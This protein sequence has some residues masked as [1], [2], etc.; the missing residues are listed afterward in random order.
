MLEN[1]ILK[2]MEILTNLKKNHGADFGLFLR[3]IG[4][5]NKC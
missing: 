1:L 5:W 4:F 3:V 2:L